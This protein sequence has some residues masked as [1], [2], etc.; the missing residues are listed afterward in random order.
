MSFQR[1]FI[2]ENFRKFIYSD[3]LITAYGKVEIKN[4]V[5]VR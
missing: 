1:D 3:A 5:K 2:N 4:K